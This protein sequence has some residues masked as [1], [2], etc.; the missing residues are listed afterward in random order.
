MSTKG[1]TAMDFSGTPA[2]TPRLATV[3]LAVG[4]AGRFDNQNLSTT[5]YASATPSTAP[6]AHAMVLYR[7][8]GP[9]AR[10]APGRVLGPGDIA[11]AA[12]W[13]D[14]LSGANNSRTRSINA[15][16]VS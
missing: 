2:D 8:N 15:A 9:T 5:K 10:V 12:G 11:V 14:A 16:D 4:A 3:V 13:A 7:Q 6:I 1:S